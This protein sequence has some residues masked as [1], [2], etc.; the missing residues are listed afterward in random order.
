M[1]FSQKQFVSNICMLV[2]RSDVSPDSSKFAEMRV[3]NLNKLE[4][5]PVTEITCRLLKVNFNSRIATIYS[6]ACV[7]QLYTG[8]IKKQW[9]DLLLFVYYLRLK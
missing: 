1:V 9:Y 3:V 7:L 4:E 5:P 8:E 6:N 2:F